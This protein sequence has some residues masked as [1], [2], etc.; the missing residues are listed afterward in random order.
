MRVLEGPIGIIRL[1]RTALITKAWN[2]TTNA[3]GEYVVD[4]CSVESPF[5][6]LTCISDV[7]NSQVTSVTLV[8]G[9][10][11][12][13]IP[14][15]FSDDEVES[16]QSVSEPTDWHYSGV[17]QHDAAVVTRSVSEPTDRHDSGVQQHD[18]VATT[19]S[20]LEPTDRHD[21]GVQQHD[22][23]ATTRSVSEPIDRHDSKVQLLAISV[24]ARSVSESTVRHYSG[25]QQH[26]EICLKLFTLFTI[27]SQSHSRHIFLHV[28]FIPLWSPACAEIE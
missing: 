26:L 7:D 24:S 16:A 9:N 13:T 2:F 6:G 15:E 19:R 3:K 8:C 21:S 22:A 20:V 12:G 25:V 5:M 23:V 4:P 11:S 10:L 14:E 28:L 1:W 27:S 17:Q 18:V